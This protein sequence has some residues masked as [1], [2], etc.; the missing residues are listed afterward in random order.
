MISV[1][2]IHPKFF[3]ELFHLSDLDLL[4]GDVRESGGGGSGDHEEALSGKK[5]V[6]GYISH[7]KGMECLH[8]IPFI[9]NFIG[10]EW[11]RDF[12]F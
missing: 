12:V 9:P 10:G 11:S 1:K 5:E 6:P 3:I 4:G 2:N 8:I 7:L